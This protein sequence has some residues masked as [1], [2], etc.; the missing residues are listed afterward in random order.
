MNNRIA[1][2][3]GASAGIGAATAIRLARDFSG[4]VLVA[5]RQTELETT[6][7]SVTAAGATPLVVAADLRQ[8]A[9]ADQVI[10][11][12]LRRFGRIDAVVNIAGAVPQ[13]H[14]LEMTDEQWNDGAEMKLHG[15]RR[16]TIKAWPHLKETRGSVIFTSGNSA[17]HPKP[18]FAAVAAINAAIVAL[19]KA[20]AEQG[21]TDGVQ[22]NS[23]LP[24]PVMSNRRIGFLSKWS[25]AN[26]LTMEE[27]RNK[28]LVEAHIERYGEPAE[29]AELMAFLLSPGARWLT[30]S[31][32][33][34]D[35]G[36][37]KSI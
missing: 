33:R 19:A 8:A 11:E 23:V 6:A 10:A 27:A 28:F 37:D 25:A 18:G 9:A 7:R 36:E 2:V 26:K 5:R 14:L 20:F 21:I 24:G 32:I 3:T 34:M 29:I 30:G 4:L 22:V 31:A 13:I 1:I 17:Q 35:G 12:T 16:L 15:A